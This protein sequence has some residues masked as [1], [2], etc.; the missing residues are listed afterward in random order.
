VIAYDIVECRTRQ[1]QQQLHQYLMVAFVDGLSWRR[2]RDNRRWMLSTWRVQ[3]AASKWAHQ[4]A[5]HVND[6]DVVYH[7]AVY[8]IYE[9]LL[10]LL[11][12]MV[13]VVLWVPLTW[14]RQSVSELTRR[15]MNGRLYM[16][17]PGAPAQS[18]RLSIGL[19]QTRGPAVCLASPQWCR[20]CRPISSISW[21]TRCPS[22]A[23]TT[24]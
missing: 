3:A 21:S 12:M 20:R 13:L 16:Q 24:Y 10:L 22:V 6:D 14:V 1:Q 15:R 9:S 19:D 2:Q 23:M 8:S 17:W 5:Q 7:L 4:W 11:Q 18:I